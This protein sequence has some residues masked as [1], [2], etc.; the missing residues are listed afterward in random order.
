MIVFFSSL[1]LKLLL[2][3]V[4]QEP[5][6]TPADE[7]K[8]FVL[9]NKDL[10]IEL[11]AAEPMV[12]DPIL[13]QFDEQGRMWVVEMRGYMPDVEATNE[14]APVGRLSVLEDSNADGLMDKSTVFLDS[15]VMPR[16][17]A[18]VKNGILIA[19]NGALYYVTDQ[20]N[21]LHPETTTLVD[22][23]YAG[24]PSPEHSGNGLLRAMDGWHYNA[25]SKKRYRLY[26]GSWQTDSTEF[27]GQFGITQNDAGLL[28]YNYNWSQLHGDLVPPNYLSRNKNHS[29]STGIDYGYTNERIIHPLRDSYATNRGYIPGTLDKNGRLLEFTAA[30]SPHVYRANNLGS[31]YYG[32]A[33]VCEPV[34]NLVKRNL[35]T[36]KGAIPT[37]FDPNPGTEFLASTDERFR[38]V[39]LQTGP[40]GNLYV[41]DMYKG[42]MQHALYETPYLKEQYQ[43]RG[44]DKHLHK[45]RIWR[46]SHKSATTLPNQHLGKLS[47]QALVGMLQS[48][49]AY[50]RETA[51]RLLTDYPTDASIELLH[52]L[53]LQQQPQTNPLAQHHAL[54]VLS[55][56]DKT[57]P[58]LCL[59]LLTH[60]YA[61][62][63]NA[64]L[65]QAEKH[66][67]DNPLFAQKLYSSLLQ[68]LPHSTEVHRLQY[69][70][71]AYIFPHNHRL[72][73]IAKVADYQA[74]TPLFR[75]AALSSI[76]GLE[77]LH[78]QQI[79]QGKLKH[80]STENQH[81]LVEMLVAATLKHKNP[82]QITA[83]LSLLQ[84]NPSSSKATAALGALALQ[85]IEAPT[86]IALAAKPALL[87][88]PKV[89]AIQQATIAQL[90][91][92]PGK[93][94][95]AASSQ[96]RL[97]QKPDDLRAFA[98]GRQQ[99]L[100]VCSGCHGSSGKGM[101][102]LAP[103]LAGSD[104]VTGSE[105]RLALLV[106]HGIEGPITVSG[107]HYNTPAILPTMPAMSNLDDAT[108]TN[109]LTYI[110][111][112]WGNN[113]GPMPR[114]LVGRTRHTTQGR[115]LPW[116]LPELNRHIDSLNTAS[117]KQ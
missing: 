13:V 15:L 32:N 27:R 11:V 117:K 109:I 77:Y 80:Q 31:Q 86:P 91:A 14:N 107:K 58:N 102:R 25:K 61:P 97:L 100:N 22:K 9:N 108:I 53:L 23:D 19:H 8:T 6:R 18:F 38:P 90:F 35:I 83:L 95:A 42:I 52:R 84:Q 110:R 34:A 114:F 111:N 96:A 101:P 4:E 73:L 104:W 64:A 75:D 72:N 7:L 17:M 65:R 3:F 37:A 5:P 63:A 30:C 48:A 56:L 67:T 41:V 79:W 39:S 76:Q 85:G 2:F 16:A 43:K 106:M 20:N 49:N 116:T 28:L 60:S 71:S 74:L 1:I 92:W 44:L 55:V 66:A 62:L 68:H 93:A 81:I 10:K 21:D 94:T 26:Q 29:P 87:S 70:L 54:A 99:Y 113:A 103:P 36:Y 51:Q 115:I 78:L 12:Q 88:N 46:I 59:S 33:F 50:H 45:G 57:T 112:E 105:Q 89:P 98:R 40:D 47:P 82:T 69:L 24:N